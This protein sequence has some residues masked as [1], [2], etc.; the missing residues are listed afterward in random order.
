VQQADLDRQSWTNLI[1]NALLLLYIMIAVVNTLVMATAARSREFAM[2]RLA[3]TTRR[4]VQRMM[5]LESWVVVA[6]AVLVGS[7]VAIAP[8]VGISMA[9]TESFLPHISL[10]AYLGIVGVTAL[11]GLLSIVIPARSTMR[12]R[13]IHA[14]GIGE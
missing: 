3:G 14:I 8:L 7:A 4:Q 11:L 9:M 5:F 12:A 1:A 10:V 2:L 13:P 6:T